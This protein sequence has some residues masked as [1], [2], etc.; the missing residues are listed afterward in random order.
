MTWQLAQKSGEPDLAYSPGGPKL[1]NPSTARPARLR[2][3]ILFISLLL[4]LCLSISLI[5][6]LSFFDLVGAGTR[7]P[8]KGQK[9]RDAGSDMF[10]PIPG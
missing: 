5:V 1:T 9:G 8:A 3:I 2:R 4:L 6:V 7:K 10:S